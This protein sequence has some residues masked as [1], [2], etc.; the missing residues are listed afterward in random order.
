MIGVE[1]S[2]RLKQT[3]DKTMMRLYNKYDLERGK[4]P[5]HISDNAQAFEAFVR[6]NIHPTNYHE[7]VVKVDGAVK[8]ELGSYMGYN[9]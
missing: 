1:G 7:Y 5:V 4:R 8:Q 6:S 2:K 3:E 9:L